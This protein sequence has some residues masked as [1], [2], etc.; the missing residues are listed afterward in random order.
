MKKNK[1]ILITGS[2]G[3]IG[4]NLTSF[5][6]EK[7]SDLN[8]VTTARTENSK[9]V[10][11]DSSKNIFP[12][13]NFT[14]QE[15]ILVHLATYFSKNP[16]DKELIY[17]SNETF[18][19]NLLFELGNYNLTGVIYTN[20]MYSFYP[21]VNVRNLDYTKSKNNFSKFLLELTAS[22]SIPYEEI[23]LDNTFGALD[24]R[25]KIIPNIIKAIIFDRPNPV[26]NKDTFINLVSIRDVVKR[27]DASLEN[28]QNIST[29]FLNT[30][31]VNINS[32]YRF[33]LKYRNNRKPDNGLLEFKANSYKN[34]RP[35]NYLKGINL[36][37]LTNS[38]IRELK[39]YENK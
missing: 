10:F 27:L 19:K 39:S 36:T 18:G 5:L 23:F 9:N 8:I 24:T 15:I 17:L 33:L 22:K 35:E 4:K 14:D 37:K 7:N 32:V 3:Y 2:T 31:S 1:T 20:T 28:P 16:A 34:P 12:I 11:L 29:S 26:I 13:E 30:Q 25:P 21:S 38:L 6:K